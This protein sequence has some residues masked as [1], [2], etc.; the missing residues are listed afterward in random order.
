MTVY[1]DACGTGLGAVLMQGG[2]IVAYA[3]RQ[4]KPHEKRYPTHDLELA[5]IVF[6]LK[7]WINYHLGER[8]ELFT[9][10]KSLKYLFSQ[11][12]LNLRQQRWLEFLASYDFDIAYT[13]ANILAETLNN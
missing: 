6:S 13:P 7:M 4:L 8:F 11:K 3:S 5:A 10:H 1:T 12:D 9:D 2:R